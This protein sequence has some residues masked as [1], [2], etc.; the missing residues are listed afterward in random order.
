[1]RECDNSKPSRLWLRKLSSSLHGCSAHP[2]LILKAVHGSS[3][4]SG[5]KPT[6]LR[7]GMVSWHF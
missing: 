3:T 1:M 7:G 4:T 6:S 2:V 5:A